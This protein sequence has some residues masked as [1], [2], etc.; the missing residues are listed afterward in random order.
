MNNRNMAAIHHIQNI[1]PSHTNN[2]YK[3]NRVLKQGQ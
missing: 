2:S 3:G 1:K